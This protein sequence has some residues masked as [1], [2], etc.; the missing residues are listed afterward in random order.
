MLFTRLIINE[1]GKYQILKILF[2]LVISVFAVLLVWD[3]V[4][5]L[6]P[7]Y[8]PVNLLSTLPGYQII[9]HCPSDALWTHY[10]GN[11]VF[12]ITVSIC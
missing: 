5:L 4:D 3:S 10:M 6:L 9:W 1:K 11:S 7:C 12:C 2:L 8:I